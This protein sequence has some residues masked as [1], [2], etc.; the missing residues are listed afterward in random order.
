MF[1]NKCKHS[2][3]LIKQIP[4]T[5]AR[6]PFEVCKAK[7]QQESMKVVVYRGGRQLKQRVQKW[8]VLTPCF[9]RMQHLCQHF[10]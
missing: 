2:Q 10:V 6:H 7:R 5:H 1:E 8:L 3:S 9:V 4:I